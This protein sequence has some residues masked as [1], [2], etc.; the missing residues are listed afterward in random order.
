[1]T[2]LTLVRNSSEIRSSL[3]SFVRGVSQNT[4]R[5]QLLAA[6]TMYWVY[7]ADGDTFGPSK[8]VGFAKMNFEVYE[9]AIQHQTTGASFS[10]SITKQAI[11]EATG[12]A[13]A[14]NERLAERL[15]DWWKRTFGLNP[16]D[17]LDTSKWRFTTLLGARNY[18]VLLANPARYRIEQAVSELDEDWWTI[19]KSAVH[20]GDRVAIWKASGG[21]E[22]RGVVALGE[23]LS[24]P[25]MVPEPPGSTR[26]WVH[27]SQNRIARRAKIRYIRLPRGPLW[28]DKDGS[29]L[30]AQMSVARASGGGVFRVRPEQ[31]PLLVDILGGWPLDTTASENALVAFEAAQP[32]AGGQGFQG[33]AIARKKIEDLAMAS[34]KAYFEAQGYVVETRGK[35]FDLLCARGSETIYV[36]V[37]GTTTA[38]CNVLLTPNEVGFARDH[39]DS[40]VLYILSEILVEGTG[41]VV[42]TRG[43]KSRILRP[44]R[45]DRGV[46]SP[47]GYSYALPVAEA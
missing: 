1:M 16:F 13:Y 46:L 24:E 6:Q 43:G 15:R 37:K 26:Y 25:T 19:P 8:F 18:W 27:P 35:P 11:E 38:G 21:S 47:I 41:E 42:T 14:A 2:K 7:D 34:A 20:A 32:R 36:E 39:S 40:M 44:W 30:L 33:S 5:A 10:G 9:Q 23:V 22:R 31:W 29:G 3:G 12:L 4:E 28:L 45:L 17:G